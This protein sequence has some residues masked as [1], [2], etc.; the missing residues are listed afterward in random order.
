M[1]NNDNLSFKQAILYGIRCFVLSCFVSSCIIHHSKRND[2]EDLMR[3]AE[4]TNERM[5]SHEILINASTRIITVKCR[6]DDSDN[7]REF[8]CYFSYY[9]YRNSDPMLYAE[10]VYAKTALQEAFKNIR[11]KLDYDCDI[12]FKDYIH[13]KYNEEYAW[14]VTMEQKGLVL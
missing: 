14:Q 7:L 4:K 9:D 1:N 12:I 6:Y 10:K 8:S 2:A 11:D 13:H 5:D 3:K